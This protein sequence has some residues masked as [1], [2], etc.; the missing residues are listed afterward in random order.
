MDEGAA[1]FLLGDDAASL[2]EAARTVDVSSGE[3]VSSTPS[4][5]FGLKKP[6]KDF[7]P[8]D[9][10]PDGVEVDLE[11]FA[12]MAGAGWARLRGKF[13]ASCLSAEILDGLG[14]SPGVGVT[15]GVVFVFRVGVDFSCALAAEV[16]RERVLGG[17]RA[18][19]SL[20][21]LRLSTSNSGSRR[22]DAGSKH[23]D[24]YSCCRSPSLNIPGGFM[25]SRI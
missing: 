16:V 2:L 15:D 5:D 3:K 14:V 4:R 24:E 25:T 7:W 17:L 19:M 23:W 1:P 9:D 20:M 11:R 10:A 12:G 21:L 8:E 18:N 6:F 13:F 22:P